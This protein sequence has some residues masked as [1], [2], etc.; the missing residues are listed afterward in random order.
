MHSGVSTSDWALIATAGFTALTALA[1]FGSVFRV[2]RDRWRRNIPEMHLE[3]LA[4]VPNREMRMTVVN[5][6]APARE[7]RVIGTIG[8]FG[9]AT[10]T[11]PTSYW[12]PGETRT[13]RIGMPLLTDQEARAFVEARDLGKRR[14]VIATVGG[15]TYR[16]PLR[17][18]KKLSAAK[19]WERLF[20]GCPSPLDVA[21]KPMALELIE[22]L[23]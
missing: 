12:R 13:Y 18:A 19:E 2:E 7:V 21:H 6:A 16:W 11:P 1:A 8:D 14:L 15:A 17:K 9:W 4:D 20:P 23:T 5:L 10:L 22:R 3:I